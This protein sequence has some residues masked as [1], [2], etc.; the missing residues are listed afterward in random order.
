MISSTVEWCVCT[1]FTCS[2]S[3]TKDR[4]ATLMQMALVGTICLIGCFFAI[5]SSIVGG[6]FKFNMTKML[7]GVQSNW[8]ALFF[9]IYFFMKLAHVLFS[10]IF[11]FYLLFA[12]IV[13]YSIEFIKLPEGAKPFSEGRKEM[14]SADTV[15][16]TLSINGFIVIALTLHMIQ[17]I[18]WLKLMSSSWINLTIKY[19]Y[20]DTEDVETAG[21]MAQTDYKD[22]DDSDD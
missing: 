1:S 12:F 10:V 22:E 2:I 19:K 13:R 5:V 15:L 11:G 4:L 21:P 16:R 20:Q 14:S 18:Y 6:I 9:N 3:S 8:T 7:D 17:N